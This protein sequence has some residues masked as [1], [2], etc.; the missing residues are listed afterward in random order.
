MSVF[1]KRMMV[2]VITW[3]GIFCCEEDYKVMNADWLGDLKGR[4]VWDKGGVN[5][6]KLLNDEGGELWQKHP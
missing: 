2:C 6:W 3:S 4:V 5:G 1:V